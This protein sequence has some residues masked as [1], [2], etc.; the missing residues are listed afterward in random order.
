M[1]EGTF[2]DFAENETSAAGLTTREWGDVL[3]SETLSDSQTLG[4][5]F[6]ALGGLKGYGIIWWRKDA[7]AGEATKE[8]P[9]GRRIPR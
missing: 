7:L 4:V 2:V 1:I 9:E 5:G 3:P 8:M 6:R